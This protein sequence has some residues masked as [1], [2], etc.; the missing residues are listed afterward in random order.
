MRVVYLRMENELSHTHAEIRTER[1]G[2]APHI[3]CSVKSCS[4]QPSSLSLSYGL[5][6][7]CTSLQ[8]PAS[9]RDS[10]WGNSTYLLQLTPN[11]GILEFLGMIDRQPL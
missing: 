7:M 10:P 11:L 2:D 8:N 6:Y 1:E 4:R 9:P 3:E 5:N